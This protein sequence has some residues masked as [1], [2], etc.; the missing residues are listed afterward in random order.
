MLKSWSSG[1]W[2][3]WIYRKHSFKSLFSE[4]KHQWELIV[5]VKNILRKIW[6]AVKIKIYT[7]LSCLN[8][9]YYIFQRR[10]NAFVHYC[11]SDKRCAL[12]LLCLFVAY[13]NRINFL[14]WAF[15]SL[16]HWYMQRLQFMNTNLQC[17][18]FVFVRRINQSWIRRLW[19]IP[20]IKIGN[21]TG[22]NTA[23][24]VFQLRV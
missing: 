5:K 18:I 22:D 15:F 21:I 13:I 7:L 12:G 8:I 11:C 6:K 2:W 3:G 4:L 17:N 16:R 14:L 9:L 19:R 1:V 23:S 10:S 20:Y 24:R